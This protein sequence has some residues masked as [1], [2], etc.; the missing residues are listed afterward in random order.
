V[1]DVEVAEIGSL[2]FSNGE[3]LDDGCNLL[4]GKSPLVVVCGWPAREKKKRPHP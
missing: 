2:V 1:F 4:H 3:K